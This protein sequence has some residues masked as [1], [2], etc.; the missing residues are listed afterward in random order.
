MAQLYANTLH[1]SADA[2]GAAGWQNVLANGTD[3]AAVLLGFSE[4]AEHEAMTASRIEVGGIQTV[5]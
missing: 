2:A 1:R 4:S 3:R 5:G